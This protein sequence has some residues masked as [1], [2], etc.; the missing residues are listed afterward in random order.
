MTVAEAARKWGLSKRLVQRMVMQ[1][2]VRVEKVESPVGTGFYWRVL[3]EERP[4]KI[5]RWPR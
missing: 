2:R 3:D 4:A 1:G 5:Q